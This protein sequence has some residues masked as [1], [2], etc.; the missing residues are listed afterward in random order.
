MNK[1]FM[2]WQNTK[3]WCME[4]PGKSAA[5]VTPIGSFT[6]VFTPAA[7]HALRGSD[8]LQPAVYRESVK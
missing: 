2:A 3:A 8:E 5:I 7:T 4:N 1:S 6:I